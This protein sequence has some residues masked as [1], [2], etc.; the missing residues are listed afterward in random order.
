MEDEVVRIW[1][2]SGDRG[3]IPGSFWEFISSTLRPDRLWSP[4]S[5]LSNGYRGLFPWS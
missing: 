2:W 5:I 1:K 4:P 3:S